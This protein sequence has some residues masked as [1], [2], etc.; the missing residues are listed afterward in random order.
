LRDQSQGTGAG[1]K[2]HTHKMMSPEEVKRN[3]GR[4]IHPCV[5]D[6]SP[7][8]QWQLHH[9]YNGSYRVRVITAAIG[10]MLHAKK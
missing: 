10:Y 3:R 7:P 9:H 1:G 6:P 5:N 2:T 8:L 4:W